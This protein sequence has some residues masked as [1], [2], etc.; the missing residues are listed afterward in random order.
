MNSQ[1]AKLVL[2]LAMIAGYG[3]NILFAQQTTTKR[4]F[5]AEIQAALEAQLKLEQKAAES[6]TP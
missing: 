4:N 6:G 1:M 5:D 2:A 3:A